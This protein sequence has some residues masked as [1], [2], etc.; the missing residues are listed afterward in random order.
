MARGKPFEKGHTLSKG[1]GRPKGSK[2]LVTIL[3]EG[4]L[5]AV[6]RQGGIAWLE[7]QVRENPKA[8]L[9]ALARIEP[10]KL[11]VEHKGSVE[12]IVKGLSDADLDT[13]ISAALAKAGIAPPA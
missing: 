9:A 2:N 6:N 13:R 11:D 10:S 3:R 8:V 5:E 4:L 7:Q 1:K 12:H